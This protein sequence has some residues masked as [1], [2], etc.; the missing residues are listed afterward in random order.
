MDRLGLDP[1]DPFDMIWEAQASCM[2]SR[3]NVSRAM[4]QTFG[5]SALSKYQKYWEEV[6]GPK[7]KV[8][9]E[10]ADKHCD[11]AMV[12]MG[13]YL[14]IG[15]D[16]CSDQLD[17]TLAYVLNEP[18][19][20]K[21]VVPD[22]PTPTF[23]DLTDTDATRTTHDTDTDTGWESPARGRMSRTRSE[24]QYLTPLNSKKTKRKMFK[25][26]MS[27]AETPNGGRRN[28][29]GRRNSIK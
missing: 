14:R 29:K 7:Y 17:S 8:A 26:L 2:R 21:E 25:N 1:T 13:K 24:N 23:T 20:N 18:V 22:G 11:A 19:I 4:E 16:K 10:A 9:A 15:M 12:V 28:G 6:I 5:K 3:T 27:A